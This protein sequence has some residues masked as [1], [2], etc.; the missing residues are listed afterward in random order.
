MSLGL[1][2]LP[3][4]KPIVTLLLC[5]IGLLN[6]SPLPQEAQ[7]IGDQASSTSNSKYQVTHA[8]PRQRVTTR[9]CGSSGWQLAF[10][11]H[12][13]GAIRRTNS[14]NKTMADLLSQLSAESIVFGVLLIICGLILAF[15]GYRLFNVNA[16]FPSEWHSR[17]EWQMHTCPLNLIETHRSFSSWPEHTREA[18]LLILLF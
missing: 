5:C 18:S 2:T 11:C 3:C 1:R 6:A 10:R 7:S 13:L 16:L 8:S 4:Y 14:P 17:E 15:F 12:R 9:H